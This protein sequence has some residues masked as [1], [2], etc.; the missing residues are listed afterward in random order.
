MSPKDFRRGRDLP[1]E[2]DAGGAPRAPDPR[3]LRA[4][5][6]AVRRAREVSG[7][8]PFSPGTPP[9]RDPPAPPH[10]LGAAGGG[11]DGSAGTRRPGERRLGT[12]RGD[13]RRWFPVAA[14]ALVAVIVLALVVGLRHGSS[15]HA[16]G[17]TST[18]RPGV[19]TTAPL[20]TTTTA[21]ATTTTSPP[22]TIPPTTSTSTTTTSS[23]TSTTST[24][25]S[26]TT[27]AGSAPLIT[28]ITPASG[29]PGSVVT[30][31]GR[32]FYS[33]NGVVLARFNGQPAP[34]DCPSQQTC[35][36]TVPHLSGSPP[37]VAVTITTAAGTSNPEPFAYG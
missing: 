31:H 5:E 15:P 23:T 10:E 24:T 14:L 12:W 28:S 32:N 16:S 26:T 20:A 21:P 30:V 33:S 2:P 4:L 35:K 9:P 11:R 1:S 7:R 29:T 3:A 6:D 18:S 34:T 27:P 19:S 22:S 13:W 37:S 25:T 36:V 8:E 17:G